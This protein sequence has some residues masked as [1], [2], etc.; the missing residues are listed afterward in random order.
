MTINLQLVRRNIQSQNVNKIGHGPI[1]THQ[2]ILNKSQYSQ[3]PSPLLPTS[4]QINATQ[5]RLASNLFSSNHDFF[6][7]D[8]ISSLLNLGNLFLSRLFIFRKILQQ[9]FNAF[10]KSTTT[11]TIYVCNSRSRYLI[12]SKLVDRCPSSLSIS[13]MSNREPNLGIL[14]TSVERKVNVLCP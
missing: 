7:R 5:R 8:P 1:D 12:L 2:S 9:Y 11:T 10:T 13:L 3:R 6:Q 14:L 4:K